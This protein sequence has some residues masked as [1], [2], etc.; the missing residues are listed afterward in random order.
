MKG[1]QIPKANGWL[2]G[3]PCQDIS[4]AGKQ[5]GMI[6]G[7][8][9]SGLF[10][11]IMRLIGEVSEKPEWILAENVKAVSK[12]IPTIEEEYDKAG[13]RLVSPQLYNSKYWGVPQNRERYFLLGIRKDLDKPFVFPQQQTDFIPK[14]SSVLE[15][16]VDEKYYID[17]LKAAKI[18]EQAIEK[19][20]DIKIAANLN[21]YG[22]DQMNRI[23]SP[24]GISPTALVVSGGGREIKILEEIQSVFTD[25]DGAAYCCDA[26]YAKG[27]SPD[28]VGTGRRTQVIEQISKETGL[29]YEGGVG[30]T[31]RVGGKGSLSAKHNYERLVT[32][33]FRVRK[34]TPREYARLQGFP[35]T[36]EQIVSNSQ[37]YKQM[38]NAVTVNVSHAIA[39]AIGEQ[40]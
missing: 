18:I 39:K 32:P 23:Y 9:R 8:T 1:E 37:F 30:K 38:G 2:F 5:A 25:K 4:V 13:Y 31:L 15:E 17:D 12:F 26:N 33:Q 35:D 10:Y 29:L 28:Y 19:L 36:Y 34:L 16:N 14:L 6:K 22:N 27:I 20:D 7:E 11:E 24:E 21:H 3:F 40:L